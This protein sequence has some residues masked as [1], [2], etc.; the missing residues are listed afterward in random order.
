V[1]NSIENLSNEIFY[2]IFDYLDAWDICRAFSNL[3]YRFEQ[4]ITCSSVRY[5]INIYFSTTKDLFCHNYKE[6]KHQ[7][8]SIAF[9]L[10]KDS[11]NDLLIIDYSFNNLQSILIEDIEK[12]KLISLLIHLSDLPCLYSLNIKTID[13]IE[14]LTNIYQ[15]IFSLPKLKSNK[16][17]LYG[18]EC[19]I[20]IPISNN[21]QI[22][23]IEYLNIAHWYT[24]DELCALISYTPNLRHLKLS[25][26]NKDESNIEDMLPNQNEIVHL[27]IFT[28]YL[29]FNEFEFFIEKLN[30]KL[31]IL[32]VV[33]SS[34][35][36]TYLHANRWQ[37]LLSENL[38]QL[39]KFSLRYRESG[40][41]DNYPIYEGK[42]NEFISP[43]WIQRNLI[44]DIEIYEY[45]IHYFVRPLK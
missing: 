8:Y 40:Y 23:P 10:P 4:L 44:F 7:I 13:L 2:E 39:E 36:I 41:G 26:T 24:F 30:S 45:N 32:N 14:D 1:V 5:K 21:K 6:I 9:Y 37:K 35:D 42:L 38:P 12:D 29:S 11:M 31:K 27:S 19:S 34:R 16:L 28:C 22:S 20:S 15:L 43:F 3:N 18:N 25:H 33:L 17:G